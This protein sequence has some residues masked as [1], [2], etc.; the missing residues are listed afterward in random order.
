MIVQNASASGAAHF[1]I[2]MEQHTAFAARLAA[3]FGND[4]FEPVS[5]REQML[6]VIGHHDAGWRALDA[7]ALRD[8]ATGLPFHLVRTPFP[9]LVETSAAS[10][11][12]N[13]AQHPYCEL[14]SS[15]HNWGLYNGRYGLS[16]KVLLD[17]LA[18]ENRTLAEPML[19]R[20]L[21]RQR[22][23]R[24]TLA[25]DAATALWVEEKHLLQNYKQLQFFDTLALYFNCSSEDQRGATS[26]SHVPHN[27]REDAEVAIAPLGDATYAFTPFPF[28]EDGATLYF[29]GRYLAP[30]AEGPD[31]RAALARTPVA[32]QTVRL[33]AAR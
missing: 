21:E 6:Y 23:L 28:A 31:V 32:S 16:D 17:D 19:E 14:I 15:M 13:G 25:A 11:D 5:P 1:V 24:A 22:R 12:F 18:A 30:V 3:L 9:R 20:E 27:A 26:F 10:P 4:A 8:P 29:E 7:Q 33:V 2:T